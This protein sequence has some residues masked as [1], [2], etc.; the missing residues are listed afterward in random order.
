MRV[1]RRTVPAVG[2]SSPRISF[3]SVVLPAPF[4][5]IRPTLSPRRIVAEKSLTIVLAS[6]AGRPGGAG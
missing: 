6:L 5:P 4:G 3:S 1:P 2:S